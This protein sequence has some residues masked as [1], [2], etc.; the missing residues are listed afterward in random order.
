MLISRSINVAANGTVS[1][2]FMAEPQSLGPKEQVFLIHAS[3]DGHRACFHTRVVVT[4][5]ALDLGVGVG[6][7][8]GLDR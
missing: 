4:C 1:F 6:G 5:A 3:V 7:L 2:L 8:C